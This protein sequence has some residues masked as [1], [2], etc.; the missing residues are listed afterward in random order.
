MNRDKVEN[1]GADVVMVRQIAKIKIDGRGNKNN[2]HD[3]NNQV[4]LVTRFNK[5]YTSLRDIINSFI[6]VN[7]SKIKP[8]R[9]RRGK[10]YTVI[11]ATNISGKALAEDGTVY[12]I[13]DNKMSKMT[14]NEFKRQFIITNPAHKSGNNN[15][16]YTNKDTVQHKE[17]KSTMDIVRDKI[18]EDAGI[19]EETDTR[20]SIVAKIVNYNN[21]IIGYVVRDPNGLKHRMSN[22]KVIRLA[23]AGKITNITVKVIS[24]RKELVG[25]NGVNL[26]NMSNIYK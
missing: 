26:S 19:K 9:L 16:N 25:E 11:A 4:Y 20:G 24:G 15:S 5:C 6:H 7:G 21:D 10:V 22:D 18:A 14:M 8:N 2:E 23:E 1:Y 3:V 13:I 17:L 12:V